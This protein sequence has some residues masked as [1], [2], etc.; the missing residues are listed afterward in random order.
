MSEGVPPPTQEGDVVGVGTSGVCPD[1]LS[2]RHKKGS[3]LDLAGDQ[4][5]IW[6]QGYQCLAVSSCSSC[7]RTC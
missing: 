1:L 2:V 6:V 7:W 4:K 5:K 3:T